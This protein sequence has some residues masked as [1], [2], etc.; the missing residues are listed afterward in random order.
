VTTLKD[1]TIFE[2]DPSPTIRPLG[3]R[4]SLWRFYCR[5]DTLRCDLLTLNSFQEFFSPLKYVKAM[6][7]CSRHLRII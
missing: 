2:S 3:Y 4:V 6:K 7:A 5:H 1:S